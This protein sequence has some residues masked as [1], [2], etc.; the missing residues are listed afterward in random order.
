MMLSSACCELW[1]LYTSFGHTC[2]ALDSNISDSTWK[3]LERKSFVLTWSNGGSYD[4]TCRNCGL[5]CG[6]KSLSAMSAAGKRVIFHVLCL[7]ALWDLGW[8]LDTGVLFP[9]ESSSREVKELNGLWDFRADKSPNRN[10]GFEREWYKGRL[11]EVSS[12]ST[13]SNKTDHC[14]CIMHLK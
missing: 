7:C 6:T 13:N 1:L 14:V 5:P 8:L 3:Q 11:A 12:M 9:R 2:P 4:L 10:Q